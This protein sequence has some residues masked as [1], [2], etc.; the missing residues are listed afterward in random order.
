MNHDHELVTPK[1]LV[2]SKEGSQAQ[3]I[4]QGPACLC[5][6]SCM[7]VANADFQDSSGV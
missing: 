1:A 7:T 5:H 4:Q 2:Q 3:L 6:A